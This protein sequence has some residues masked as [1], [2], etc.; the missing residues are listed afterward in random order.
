MISLYFISIL[1]LKF[2]KK[3]FLNISGLN[4]KL[5][6]HNIS[7][8]FNWKSGLNKINNDITPDLSTSSDML[9]FI[10]DNDFGASTLLINA[11]GRYYNNKSL[12]KF[13]R[14]FM[15]GTLNSVEITLKDLIFEKTLRTLKLQKYKDKVTFEAKHTNII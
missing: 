11:R 5:E 4:I 8:N 2:L 10:L 14:I 7:Y 15:L 9:K 13:E 12:E 3:D 1:S 6:D